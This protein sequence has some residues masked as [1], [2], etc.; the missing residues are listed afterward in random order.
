MTQLIVTTCTRFPVHF[1]NRLVN[2]PPAC[3]FSS[4]LHQ[5]GRK[6]DLQ[7][8]PNLYC[9]NCQVVNEHWEIFHFPTRCER[10]RDLHTPYHVC[11]RCPHTLY[12]CE[13]KSGS[14]EDY[15]PSEQ[16]EQLY[17]AWSS[18]SSVLVP[19]PISSQEVT[20]AV[21]IFLSLCWADWKQTNLIMKTIAEKQVT[22]EHVQQ[23]PCWIEQ[24]KICVLLLLPVFQP[25]RK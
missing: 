13:N 5:H 7:Q 9:S 22:C 23:A 4:W 18:Y 24:V 17:C 3:H 8:L 10:E 2:F 1:Q 6:P 14:T 16:P 19:C 20:T 15:S 21:L 25:G 12:V 11:E